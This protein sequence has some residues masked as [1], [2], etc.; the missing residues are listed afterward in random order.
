MLSTGI[1]AVGPDVVVHVVIPETPEIVQVPSPV[2]AIA[3]TGPVTVA[4]KVSVEPSAAGV[5]L[6]TT[7]TNGVA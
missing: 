1:D 5:A 7:A 2:G 6:L 3:P 4:V